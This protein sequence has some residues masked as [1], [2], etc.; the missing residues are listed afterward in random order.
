MSTNTIKIKRKK[1]PNGE[2]KNKITGECEKKNK[3]IKITSP[4]SI[5]LPIPIQII[6]EPQPQEPSQNQTIKLKV[7]CKKGEHWNNKTKKCEKLG[8]YRGDIF[9]PTKK[10]RSSILG[11]KITDLPKETDIERVKELEKKTT[12]ELREIIGKYAGMQPNEASQKNQ[13][14]GA[15][16]INELINLIICI[17]NKLKNGEKLETEKQI[18]TQ[19]Q[20]IQQPSEIQPTEEIIQSPSIDIVQP[21]EQPYDITNPL[22]SPSVSPSPSPPKETLEPQ[23]N[24]EQIENNLQD[25]IGKQTYDEDTKEYNQFLLKKERLEYENNKSN[26]NNDF[27]YPS[28]D[29]PNFNLK[30]ARKKEFNDTKYNGD[31]QDI[32]KLSEIMCK[33]DFELSPHQLFVKNYL[34]FQTPYNALLLY[35]GLGTGKTCSAI[36]IAEEMRLYMKQVGLN[37]R[38]IVVA[39]PNVQNNFRLQLFDEKKLVQ[40]GE[41]WNLNTCIGSSLLKEINYVNTKGLTKEAVSR[42]IKNIINQYYYFMGYTEFAN[43]IK[44]KTSIQEN[45]GYSEKEMK[46]MY[47]KNIQRV[48]NNRQIIIDEIHNIRISDDN[49]KQKKTATL[50]MEVVKYADN[51]R[52]LLLS[53]TPMYNSYKEIIWLT[54]LLNLVDK[55]AII[56]EHDVFDKDGNFIEEKKTKEGLVIEGGREL[57]QRKLIGYISYVRGENPYTFPYRVY[58]D[59]FTNQDIKNINYPKLQMNLKP[60]DVPLKNIPVYSSQIGDYQSYGYDF[61]MKN[62]RTK[63]FNVTNI[64]GKEREMPSFEN[65]DTF[66]YTVL[67]QPLEALNIVYPNPEFD[68]YL[69]SQ[70]EENTEQ[71]ETGFIERNELIHSIIGKEGLKNVMNSKTTVSTYTLRHDFEYNTAILN[72]YGRIFHPDNILKYSSKISKICNSVMNSKGIILIYS[73]FIDGGVVPIALALEEMG[74]ARYGSSQHT[75]SLFKKQPTEPIDSITMKPKSQIDASTFNQAK[76]VMITGDKAFSP[77]NLEDI[78]Y[79]TDP[80]NKNG[81]KVKVILI[82]KA[83]SEGLDFKNI[84][85]VHILEPWYNMNRNEQI[86]GRAVRNLSHCQLPFEERNVEIYLHSTIPRNDEEPA[87]LYV[88]RLA[89]KKALQI[90][91][92]TRLLKEIAVDCILNIG[93]TN[94]TV[95]KLMTFVANQDIKIKL[96]SIVDISGNMIQ[97]E[98]QF[99]I[100][101]RPYT[102]ICDYM[103]NCSFTCSPNATVDDANIDKNTYNEEYLKMNYSTIIKRIRQLFKEQSFYKK[104]DIIKRINVVRKYPIEQIDYALTHFINNK[105]EYIIDSIGRTG[106]LINKDIFYA[107]QPIEITDERTS[108]FERNVPV[109]YKRTSIDL[110]IPK[111]IDA[112]LE[113]GSQNVVKETI[114]ETNVSNDLEK[115]IEIK[116]KMIIKKIEENLKNALL[117][118]DVKIESGENDWY[119]HLKNVFDKLIEYHKIPEDTIIKYA[120]YH[121]LDTL[122]FEERF[123]L[124]QYLFKDDSKSNLNI[125]KIIKEYFNEK[126]VTRIENNV[127][128]TGILLTDNK[129]NKTYN[130]IDWNIYVQDR[131]RPLM[132]NQIDKQDIA[133]FKQ[134]VLKFVIDMPNRRRYNNIIGFINLFKNDEV[135]FKTKDLKETKGNKGAYCQNA[136]KKDIINRI[137]MILDTPVYNDEFVRKKIVT[138]VKRN[139]GYIYNKEFENGIYKY[140]LCVILEMVMRYYNE[141]NKDNKIW[142]LDLE[143]SIINDVVDYKVL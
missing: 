82:T 17:E 108:I 96:S 27:L 70:K 81:E 26:N 110:E 98:I 41:L 28:I 80:I 29:D 56:N 107:F 116:Y 100:G 74:F 101:D 33:S 40:D 136:G 85:Q 31:I 30:I 138:K 125:E 58:P 105:N 15:R 43:Y 5:P 35:H 49:K 13:I 57:L 67:Q 71:I 50:L 84:R 140:G 2:I 131:E 75:K 7:K 134:S 118:E 59:V 76:Y 46:V 18:E 10:V 42:K 36:G 25:K 78:K 68:N 14:F 90:G 97:K 11:C 44:K 22:P 16:R 141:I 73:Q 60:I 93:Q 6:N 53:A 21:N 114:D 133:Q 99:K 79:V 62:L 121:N 112:Q 132:W 4:T 45:S 128:D 39:S 37:Q 109:D 143:K 34:S 117:V 61:I 126:L 129:L 48:F 66:G 142:F 1:C 106:Y 119:K 115:T 24:I 139:D 8:E 137:N 88:Y 135:V 123:I 130:K 20:P 38:I 120:I 32:K 69:S 104:E 103:D 47:I 124:L 77:N 102:D 94:F 23:I 83:G 92:I 111:K 3:T 91:K 51:I 122:L 63:S 127:K 95:D 52:L 72:K 87:D 86:I 55:R 12:A 65:M 64:Y 113:E 89:E 54:N 9:V 19:E